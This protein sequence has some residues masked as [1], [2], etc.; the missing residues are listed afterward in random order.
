ML[1]EIKAHK[2][3]SAPTCDIGYLAKMRPMRTFAPEAS[4][5]DVLAA[6]TQ[7]SHIVGVMG[8]PVDQGGISKVITQV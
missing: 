1:V 4:L 7:G 8:G 6:L 2:K 3:L 5:L